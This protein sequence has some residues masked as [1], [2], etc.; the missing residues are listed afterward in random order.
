M[1]ELHMQ[2]LIDLLRPKSKDN[3]QLTIKSEMK[4]MMH[5]PGVYMDNTESAEHLKIIYEII[6]DIQSQV[7]K[8][9]L[10]TSYGCE[11]AEFNDMYDPHNSNN[12]FKQYTFI[13]IY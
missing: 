3:P 13:Y 1:V 4:G 9:P 8:L 10:N 2:S 11:K 6:E 7:L 5:L 12:V